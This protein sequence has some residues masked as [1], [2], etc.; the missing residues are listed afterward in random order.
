MKKYSVF[1]LWVVEKDGHKFICL[2]DG[3]NDAYEEVL[4]KEKI[5]PDRDTFV[6]SLTKYYSKLAIISLRDR[7]PLEVSKKD[8]LL[9]YVRI[10]QKGRNSEFIIDDFLKKQEE[11]LKALQIF[12]KEYPELAKKEALETL[13]RSGILDGDGNLIGPYKEIFAP[14]K[15]FENKVSNVMEDV[16]ERYAEEINCDINNAK[17]KIKK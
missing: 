1:R 5:K 4:T 10:N 12:Q 15:T 6:E 13:Q 9:K 17:Q 14:K 11:E 7:K 3:Y 2:N 8:I 16:C